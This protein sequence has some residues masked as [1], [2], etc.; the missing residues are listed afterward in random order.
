M[1]ALEFAIT[2]EVAD[3]FPGI[4]VHAMRT[5]GFLR[6]ADR[7]DHEA[8]LR[9]AVARVAGL[10]IDRN[11]VAAFPSIAGWRDAYGAMHVRPSKFRAS[12][13]SLLRRALGGADLALPIPAVNLYNACSLNALAPV[14]A[15]DMTKLP[16]SPM[17]LRLADPDR[18]RFEPLGGKA[19]DFPISSDLVVYAAGS[20]VLCWGFNC[21]D[22]IQT[23]LDIRSDDIT[24]FSEAVNPADGARSQQAI[25]ALVV[26]LVGA[27]VECAAPVVA[28][29]ARREFR[30]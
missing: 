10:P 11:D 19:T 9:D 22:N 18:D 20:T 23:A 1:A 29:R 16:D 5:T 15:Y 24:F 28:N 14:G 8:M 25:A 12:I 4:E 13:E 3:R 17:M 27:G 26:A 7:L 21:R 2:P 30:L 6:C